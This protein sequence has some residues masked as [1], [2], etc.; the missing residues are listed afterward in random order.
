[1]IAD[2]ARVMPDAL[3]FTADATFFERGLDG[4][5]LVVHGR[6]S[7]EQQRRSHLRHRLIL[8]RRVAALGPDPGNAKAL[9]WNP[10][11]ASFE[12]AVAAIGVAV[13]RVGVIGGTEAFNLFLDRYDVFHLTRAPGV[14][15]P[16]GVP[17][18]SDVPRRSPEQVLARHGL[19]PGLSHVLDPACGVSGVTWRRRSNCR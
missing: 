10:S 11:G 14:V 12:A 6:H 16:A 13:A 1:M 4:V 18:F 15:L 19:R 3:Q 8:T 9:L 17:V 2:R 5:D 7:G